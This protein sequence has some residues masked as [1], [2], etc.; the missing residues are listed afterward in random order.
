MTMPT[1][2]ASSTEASSVD[3]PGGSGTN[4]VDA[5]RDEQRALVD[6]AKREGSRLANEARHELRSQAETQMS[7]LAENARAL[8][9]QLHCAAEG[10]PVGDGPL[11]ELAGHAGDRVDA[12]AARLEGGGFDAMA[13]DLKD[14][15]RRRPAVFLAGAFAAGI[16]AGRV[17]RNAD[18]HALV[19]AARPDGTQPLSAPGPASPFAAPNQEDLQW[20]SQP[21]MS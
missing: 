16:V 12:L 4:V 11:P 10:R 20:R 3:N 19:D 21:P 18:T 14:F 8:A 13:Q 6:T 2:E 5:A 7:R 9:S 15:A 17:L 1:T